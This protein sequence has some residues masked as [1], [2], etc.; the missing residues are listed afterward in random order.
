ME[1][2]LR[3]LPRIVNP[4]D[5]YGGGCMESIRDKL[6]AAIAEHEYYYRKLNLVDYLCEH[7]EVESFELL[8][9]SLKADIY[10]E[11][12]RRNDGH[13]DDKDRCESSGD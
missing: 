11:L 10:R 7:P 5:N 9:E 13:L 1:G 2:V 8:I 3:L 4:K 6:L 12:R